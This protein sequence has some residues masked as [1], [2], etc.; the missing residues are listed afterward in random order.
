[1]TG[2]YDPGSG[3]RIHLSVVEVTHT[4]PPEKI[5]EI[6]IDTP[7]EGWG[8]YRAERYPSLYP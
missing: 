6:A 4:M 5:W 8:A 2:I 7:D 1:M 3:L